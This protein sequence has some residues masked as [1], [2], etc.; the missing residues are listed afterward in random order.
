[1]DEFSE[2]ENGLVRWVVTVLT[3]QGDAG[4]F[5]AGI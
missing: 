2:M 3:D 5:G 1:M 4:G